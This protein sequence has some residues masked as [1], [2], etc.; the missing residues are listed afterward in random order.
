[1]SNIAKEVSQLQRKITFFENAL[2]TYTLK[3]LEGSKKKS[4]KLPYGTLSIKKQ[5]DKYE[6]DEKEILQWLKEYNQEKFIET[7]VVE[8]IN[9]KELKKEAYYN[10]GSLYIDNIPVRGITVTPQG[11]KFEIK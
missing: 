9:K 11:D 3:E 2:K 8:S 10:N 4:I 5:H 1:M 7:K 6:Y